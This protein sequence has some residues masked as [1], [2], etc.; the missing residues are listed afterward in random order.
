MTDVDIH[1]DYLSEKM[2]IDVE[3][4]FSICVWQL[5]DIL[6]RTGFRLIKHL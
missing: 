5:F 6:F 1:A 4:G 2:Q 3:I